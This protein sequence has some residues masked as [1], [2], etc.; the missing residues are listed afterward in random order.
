MR[1]YG[2]VILFG[3]AVCLLVS[4]GCA[5]LAK[6]GKAMQ[7][8]GDMGSKAGDYVPVYG[9]AIKA[10]SGILA[11]VGAGL[12]R[13]ASRRGTAIQT[14]VEAVRFSKEN[15]VPIKSAVKAASN[16]RGI[17]AYIDKWAQKY[18]PKK[19]YVPPVVTS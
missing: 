4:A 7:T 1:K 12:Y 5:E 17:A 13:V 14:L 6:V 19:P 15:Q 2:Y 3:L 18:D 10:A 16:I 9:T 11:L 8:A